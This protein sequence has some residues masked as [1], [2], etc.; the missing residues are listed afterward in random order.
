M[1]HRADHLAAECGHR[2]GG[3]AR[4]VAAIGV[5]DMREEPGLAAAALHQRRRQAVRRRPGIDRPAHRVR[6]ALRRGQFQRLRTRRQQHLVVGAR[7]LVDRQRHRGVRHVGHRI[8]VL[9]VEPAPHDGGADIGLLQVIGEHD[10]DLHAGDRAAHVLGRHLRGEHRAGPHVVHRHARHVGEHADLYGPVG[11][12][13]GAAGQQ[14]DKRQHGQQSG[15]GCHGSPVGSVA[16][17]AGA[18]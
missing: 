1:R 16:P 4:Q 14:R 6:R 7:D 8:D 18:Q 17:L 12:V 13:G 2:L 11:G 5:V 9:L 10:L 3:V 15:P